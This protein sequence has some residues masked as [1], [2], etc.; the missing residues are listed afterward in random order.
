MVSKVF[1]TLVNN[2]IVDHIEKSDLFS[3]SSM[4]LGF[5]D[6]LWMFWQLRLILIEL[7]ELLKGLG[8]LE[9]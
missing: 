7:L 4:V 1:E 6:Q 2:K 3:D 9:L 8:L 5:L